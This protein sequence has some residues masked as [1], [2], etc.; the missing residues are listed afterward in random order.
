MADGLTAGQRLRAELEAQV[1]E[2]QAAMNEGSPDEI[3]LLW[4]PRELTYLEMIEKTASRIEQ[5]DR[6]V[7]E[8]G[9]MIAGSKG[10][11]RIHPAVQEARMARTSLSQL[12][13]RLRLPSDAN[14]DDDKPKDLV[15]Q[16]AANRRWGLERG[17]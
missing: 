9:L 11:Q 8:Q 15:K 10:Q 6:L 4:E 7:D 16:R 12:L 2:A 17:W 13:D 3:E 14:V 5:L 1:L